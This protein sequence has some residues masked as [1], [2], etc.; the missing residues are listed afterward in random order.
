MKKISTSTIQPLAPLRGRIA[1]FSLIELM[2]AMTLG[3]LIIAVTM[4]VF[5]NASASRNELERTS[6][7]IENG[8]YATEV[9]ADDLRLAG[10]Y[11][12]LK[13]GDIA[14]PGALPVDQC[15]LDAANWNTWIP[16]HVQGFDNGASF[17]KTATAG[18]A[19][20]DQKANTDILLIRRARTCLA[21]AADCGVAVTDSP[22]VQVS[23]CATETTTHRLGIQGTATFDLKQKDCTTTANL[24][25]YYVR[26][27]YISTNNGLGQNIPTL[28]RLELSGTDC[29]G[30]PPCW[31]TTPLVEGIEE[32][33]VAYG[34]D[35]NGD[36]AP[37]SYSASPA[38]V[39]DWMNV[40][41]VQFHVLARNPE[42]SP[43]YTQ[44]KTYDL[45]LGAAPIT[46]ADGYRRHV[47][48]TLVRINNPA[49]RRDKP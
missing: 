35:S 9:I 27:Y 18:C 36:G 22:Y 40:M 6:R 25:Q 12:E 46:L 24:R 16:L 43:G 39:A 15:S 26:I 5:F 37:E 21:T 2:I 7:Q 41:S 19:L 13:V 48:S 28:K 45:G 3:M 29:T 1:G 17:N 20:A 34:I 10:F 47:Y 31:I 33:N 42:Q 23:L 8:R 11:G 38:S 14:P 49:G 32:F 44:S 30:T 4:I